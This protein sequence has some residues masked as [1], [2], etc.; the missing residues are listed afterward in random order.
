MSKKPEL[1][2]AFIHMRMSK[3]NINPVKMAEN[4]ARNISIMGVLQSLASFISLWSRMLEWASG[5][6]SANSSL[7]SSENL[8]VVP[9]TSMKTYWDRAFSAAGPRLWNSLSSC[10][11]DSEPVASFKKHLK[12]HLFREAYSS[13]H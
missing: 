8:L 5:S 9:K 10:V 6:L 7:R 11:K 12:T 4:D 2:T 1:K 13:I 3:D